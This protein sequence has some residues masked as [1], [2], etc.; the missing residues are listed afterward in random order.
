MIAERIEAGEYA[1]LFVEG[2]AVGLHLYNSVAFSELTG[3]NTGVEPQYWLMRDSKP[4]CGIVAGFRCGGTL[5]SPFSA[6]FG[7]PVFTKHPQPS[8]VQHSLEA[9]AAACPGMRITLPPSFMQPELN[10]RV[11]AVLLQIGRLDHADLSYHYPLDQID[12]FDE[13]L[14]RSAR[15]KLHKAASAGF[16]FEVLDPS[17]AEDAARAYAVI[18]VNRRSHGYPLAMSL[19]QVRATAAVAGGMM[20]V[21][22]IDG[23]DVASV[24]AQRVNAD[25]AQIVYWGDAP[26]FSDL[27]P[28]NLLPRYLFG[29]LARLGFRYADIGPAASGGV[30]DHGLASYK[31][32]IG[33]LP[34]LKPTFILPQ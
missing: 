30:V 21:L 5:V 2:Q 6:P 14:D 17:D 12:R 27:R 34:S 3:Q 25:V 4:R 8:T 16:R 19:E 20:M 18:E 33:C 10:A 24:V 9:L 7:G 28:M 32:S 31:E 1:R 23:T 26:G 13:R 29:Y 22:S 15:Q 11:A